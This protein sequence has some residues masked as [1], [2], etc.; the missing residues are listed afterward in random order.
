MAAPSTKP[1]QVASDVL[2]EAV[3]DRVAG[4]VNRSAAPT[5]SADAAPTNN[6]FYKVMLKSCDV[7]SGR[8]P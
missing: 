6:P 2:T 1:S 4:A 5:A 7:I 8:A 3:R